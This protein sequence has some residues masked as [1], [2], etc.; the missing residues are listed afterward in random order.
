MAIQPFNSENIYAANRGES[1]I[2]PLDTDAPLKLAGLE[3][4]RQQA[5]LKQR[6][7]DQEAIGKAFDLG[8]DKF[9]EQD[10]DYVMG[11]GR[12]FTNKMS[13]EL[14]EGKISP[15]QAL[16]KTNIFKNEWN[17]LKDQT[18]QQ[19]SIIDGLRTTINTDKDKIYDKEGT[20]TKLATYIDPRTSTD[21]T[22]KEQLK[23]VGGNVVKWR[24][25]YG[26]DWAK[27]E[28]KYDEVKYVGDSFKDLGSETIVDD[29]RI[30]GGTLS[31]TRKGV[32]PERLMER[33]TQIVNQANQGDFYATRLVQGAEDF[34]SKNISDDGKNITPEGRLLLKKFKDYSGYNPQTNTLQIKDADGNIQEIEVGAPEMKDLLVKTR[35]AQLGEATKDKEFKENLTLQNNLN[36]NMGGGSSSPTV[37]GTGERKLT[38]AVPSKDASGK[39]TG[40]S[41]NTDVTSVGGT[42]IQVQNMNIPAGNY[43]RKASDGNPVEGTGVISA[44]SASIDVVPTFKKG[45]KIGG[46]DVGGLVVSD[47]ILQGAIENGD[48]EYKPQAIIKEKPKKIGKGDYSTEQS[49]TLY[50]D[51]DQ[52][53][54]SGWFN[55][56]P[57]KDTKVAKSEYIR[58]Q[59]LATAKNKEI[60]KQKK[61]PTQETKK[62]TAKELI[63]KYKK[64]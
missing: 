7:L 50:A 28:L 36:I 43:L 25:L 48:V 9:Y 56:L 14:A 6:E 2:L 61:Q 10:T 42:N 29:K 18:L 22:V 37:F 19:K 57:D 4:Q 45:S 11:L 15:Q 54:K 62:P 44:E 1:S 63:D 23:E 40:N 41:V 27:P 3:Q 53:L 34:I 59:E 38:F 51:A 60:E 17:T 55:S 16:L 46:K 31:T 58:L 24:Q 8:S 64:K 52:I 47:D 39:V 26:L 13:K 30:S 33:S 5:R 35:I 12:D 49:E 20:E 21:P 32:N